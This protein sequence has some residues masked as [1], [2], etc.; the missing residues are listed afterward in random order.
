[1]EEWTFGTYQVK[2]L[3]GR[4]GMG[5]VYRAFDTSHDRMVALKLL[6]THL[7]ADESYRA[8]FRR[9]C[10]LAARLREP[11]VIPIHSYGE[12]D[13]RL[14]LDM[15]LVEG[16]DLGEALATTGA[17]PPGRAVEIIGQ[18]GR[19]LDAAH[20]DGLIHRDVK[21]SNVIIAE[22]DDDAV[23]VYLVDFGVAR[24][25][26]DD[27]NS[28]AL[29]QT[30]GAVGTFDYMP[31]ERFA[32]V[33]AD[34]RTDVYSLT[35]MLYECLTGQ[36]P[37]TGG[38]LPSLM[39]G[40]MNSVP[41]APSKLKPELTEAMD[42]VIARGMA[43]DPAARFPTAGGVA[44]AAR[45]ALR[46][47]TRPVPEAA[48]TPPPP[49]APDPRDRPNEPRTAW[50]YSDGAA[51]TL[52]PVPFYQP[53]AGPSGELGTPSSPPPRPGSPAGPSVADSPAPVLLPRPSL[54]PGPPP[55]SVPPY[56]PTPP[57]RSA[58]PFQ[59]GPPFQSAPPPAPPYV[60]PLGPGRP[61]DGQR[62]GSPKRSRRPMIIAAVVV[63][64]LI[65]VVATV[66]A[67]RTSGPSGI[68]PGPTTS[69]A[70]GP[71]FRV[72]S[73]A[74]AAPV[75]D[76]ALVT[77][78]PDTYTAAACTVGTVSGT[79][80]VAALQCGESTDTVNGPSIA[81]FYRYPTL[82]A[83]RNDF[84]NVIKNNKLTQAATDCP[85]IG[86]R[87]YHFD[88]TPTVVAG[89]MASYIE[90]SKAATITWTVEKS[91]ELVVAENFESTKL[92][93]M[94]TWWFNA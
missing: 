63:V 71:T 8:R 12:T 74:S 92:P 81:S 78:L 32:G 86:Y 76:P 94:C 20:D 41:P 75:L 85:T 59:S 79:E 28:N 83:L 4:G 55:Q 35:C 60:P 2:S 91:L 84:A 73:S 22:E 40:H 7:S 21:P 38:D 64:A 37:F 39:Y 56:Q 36:R 52:G 69:P 48:R 18:V 66:L 65:A 93:G 43:K 19:A 80:A 87:N 27:G 9:E 88:D 61:G 10:H 44:A 26:G 58:P 3:I 67:T 23:F 62:P 45:A 57:F 72:S 14:F 29:T 54:Q 68:Q 1:M 5:E 42:A 77:L 90:V 6:A 70:A 51:R 17:L 49:G 15:R 13:G 34:R 33:I 24:A 82:T 89:Q 11:H 16:R 31:P 30:G 50:P 46:A 53:V 25:V 47:S